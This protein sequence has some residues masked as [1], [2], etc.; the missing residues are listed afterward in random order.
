MKMVKC[1]RF[2]RIRGMGLLLFVL[3][4]YGKLGVR[5]LIEV[6]VEMLGKCILHTIGL[7]HKLYGTV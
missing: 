4:F 2:M 6:M 3:I 1:I 5:E 7:I